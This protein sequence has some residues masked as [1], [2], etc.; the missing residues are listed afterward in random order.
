MS[1]L[2]HKFNLN[3]E[4]YFSQPADDHERKEISGV[5]DNDTVV[6]LADR[7]HGK[8]HHTGTPHI[9]KT[10]NID[11]NLVNAEKN[12]VE[13]DKNPVEGVQDILQ[14]KPE[15]FTGAGAATQSDCVGGSAQEAG[16]IAFSAKTMAKGRGRKRAGALAFNDEELIE[17]LKTLKKGDKLGSGALTTAAITG[18]ITAAPEIIRAIGTLRKGKG[19]T[20]SG[21]VF[22]KNLSPDK[23]DAMENLMKQINRQKKYFKFDSA[24]NEYEVG[25]GKFGD[26]MSKAWS[27]VKEIYHSDAFK[28]IKQALLSAANNTATKY[29]DK[30]AK[31]V[32]SKVQ[33]EDLKRIVDATKDVA[34]ATKDELLDR[35]SGAGISNSTANFNQ[36]YKGGKAAEEKTE[37]LRGGNQAQMF[38]KLAEDE[39]ASD[40]ESEDQLINKKN[41]FK[42]KSVD[43]HPNLPNNRTKIGNFPKIRARSVFL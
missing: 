19:Y 34:H 35:A 41:D 14:T 3:K 43:Y 38:E 7:V 42:K 40:D 37:F 27:K 20:G 36:T 33:N 29:I 26:F 16:A 32:S 2:L 11:N 1:D 5:V 30:A 15:E 25:S 18:L 22:V 31:K 9:V 23:F 13:V 21:E 4:T 12:E 28:P 8:G 24:T 10:E 39:I 17:Q 6:N